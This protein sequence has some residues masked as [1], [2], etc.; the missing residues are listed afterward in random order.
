[1][2]MASIC[3]F[4]FSIGSPVL[5]PRE[6]MVTRILVKRSYIDTFIRENGVE[7]KFHK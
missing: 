7:T 2:Q 4:S 5:L 6:S 1:M 3:S